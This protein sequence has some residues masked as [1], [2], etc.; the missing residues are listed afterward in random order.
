MDIK[1]T[2]KLI[3]EELGTS[4]IMD[5]LFA[6]DILTKVPTQSTKNSQDDLENPNELVFKYRK[7]VEEILERKT[8]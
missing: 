2:A 1:E 3:V 7:I 8:S 5:I 6:E 4:M